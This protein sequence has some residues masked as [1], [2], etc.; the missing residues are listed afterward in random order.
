MLVGEHQC[1]DCLKCLRTQL[2]GRGAEEKLG[3]AVGE[4]LVALDIHRPQEV[5]FFVGF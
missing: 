3:V 4:N 1:T 2:R 5:L